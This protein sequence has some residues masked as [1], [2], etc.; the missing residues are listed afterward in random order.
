MTSADLARFTAARFSTCSLVSGLLDRQPFVSRTPSSANHGARPTR[1]LN[2][3]F[4]ECLRPRRQ[5]R[6]N[7][8]ITFVF[9]RDFRARGTPLPSVLH[10]GN[11][12]A[13]KWRLQHLMKVYTASLTTMLII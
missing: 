6:P 4:K 7:L 9:R 2:M 1:K 5:Q 13:S 8:L 12:P 11:T 10:L 3:G